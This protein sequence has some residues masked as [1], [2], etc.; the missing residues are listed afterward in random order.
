MLRERGTESVES[1]LIRER[2]KNHTLRVA[3]RE[4]GCGD[5]L[6]KHWNLRLADAGGRAERGAEGVLRAGYCFQL[7][8]LRDIVGLEG[9]SVTLAY[10]RPACNHG[11]VSTKTVD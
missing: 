4:H 1:L 5:R 11:V 8:R 10:S 9:D 3:D 2:S 7:Q 6:A